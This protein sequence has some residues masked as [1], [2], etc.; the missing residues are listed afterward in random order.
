MRSRR[1]ERTGRP[2]P[3]V[4]VIDREIAAEEA[5]PA[6]V[7]DIDKTYLDTRF[8]QLKHLA[9][10]PFEFG[11]DKRALPGS[12]AL[13]HALREGA[14]GHEHR[15]LFFVSASPPIL[16]PAIERKMLLDGIEWDGIAY[17]DVGRVIARGGA[18][19]LRHQLA[20]KL[21]VLLLLAREMPVGSR[22]HLFGDDVEE[23]ALIYSLFADVAAGRL[24]ARALGRALMLHG[25]TPRE[26]QELSSLAEAL[27]LIGLVEEIHLRLERHPDGSSIAPWSR[28]V[29]GAAS[30]GAMA[31]R[32]AQQGLINAASASRVMAEA[33]HSPTFWGGAPDDGF[34]TPPGWRG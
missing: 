23:D 1:R 5:G 19:R 16:A 32:L 14:S 29:L 13:L 22:L 8:S 27:P 26:A 11:V 12:V 33:G 20:F 34:F 18:R 10:I 31:D 6:F 28:H 17:K 9:R 24:R 21:G 2:Y 3:M 4:R 15:P 7:W 30:F 25:A